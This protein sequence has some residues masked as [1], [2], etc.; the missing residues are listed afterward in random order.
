[1]LL[2][3]Q[4]EAHEEFNKRVRERLDN[5]LAFESSAGNKYLR[6]TIQSARNDYL[7]ARWSTVKGSGVWTVQTVGHPYKAI[8]GLVVKSTNASRPS[9]EEVAAAVV[10]AGGKPRKELP[11]AGKY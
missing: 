7:Y 3:E 6:R 1:V 2:D 9:N 5:P 10:A 8:H 4:V 11:T